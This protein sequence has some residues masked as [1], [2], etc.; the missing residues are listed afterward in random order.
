LEK[1]DAFFED[2][3]FFEKNISSGISYLKSAH[4]AGYFNTF[5]SWSGLMYI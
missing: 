3:G 5:C 4:N 2:L 1:A